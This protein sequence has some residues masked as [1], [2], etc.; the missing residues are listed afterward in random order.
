MA[1]FE[2]FPGT[3]KCQNLS[4]AEQLNA[5]VRFLDIRCRHLNN[6]FVLHHGCVSQKADFQA[7]IGVVTRF[8]EKN[9]GE[10]VIVSLKEESTASGNTRSFEQT[11][12]SY[13]T[14][15]PGK[16]NLKADIPTL[17]SAK[18]K[19]TLL[20]RFR[21]Q[22]PK[23]IDGTDWPDNTSFIRNPL[24]IQDHYAVSDNNLK[25]REIV[26]QFDKARSSPSRLLSINFCSGN[27]SFLGIPNIPATAKEINSR[28]RE[29][30]RTRSKDRK[31]IVVMDLVDAPGCAAVYSR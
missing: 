23:G 5:G 9:P 6:A 7:V 17:R 10:C 24:S 28:L 12:D 1:F 13:V 2:P 11:F 14:K 3:A 29:Y 18:G 25:W 26:A 22:S 4:L 30:L 21:A 16:W 27:Q 19:I 15:N 31:G 20:R 8:L